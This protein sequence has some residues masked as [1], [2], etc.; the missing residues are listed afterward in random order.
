MLY[1]DHYIEFQY[2]LFIN[3]RNCNYGIFFSNNPWSSAAKLRIK[4]DADELEVKF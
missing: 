2:T 1:L 4:M 3:I